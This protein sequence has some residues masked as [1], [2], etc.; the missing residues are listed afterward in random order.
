MELYPIDLAIHLVNLVVLFLILRA[1]LFNPVRKFLAARE[2]RVAAELQEAADKNAAAEALKA[3]YAEKLSK[4]EEECQAIVARGYK[5]GAE[6]AEDIA[7]EAKAE[8]GRIVYQAKQEAQDL[9]Q[10]AMDSAKDE[11]TDLAVTMAGRVLRFDEATKQ[12]I[13]AGETKKTG[14]KTGVLKLA[15]ETDQETIDKMR[16]QLEAMLGTTLKLTIEVDESLIGGY[17]AY[18]DGRVYDFSY[19]AQLQTM[20]QKLS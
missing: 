2:A 7:K 17:A 4:A 18:V 13:A 6:H 5:E 11:L 15:M 20:K 9:K 14:T 12:R 8:A 16:A 3:D 1:L 10:R 19:A